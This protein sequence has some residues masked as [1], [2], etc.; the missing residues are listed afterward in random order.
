MGCNITLV[1]AKQSTDADQ[2]LVTIMQDNSKNFTLFLSENLQIMCEH[3]V[4]QSVFTQNVSNFLYQSQ[5][6][7]N[8]PSFRSANSNIKQLLKTALNYKTPFVIQDFWLHAEQLILNQNQHLSDSQKALLTLLHQCSQLFLL[9]QLFSLEFAQLFAH[10]SPSEHHLIINSPTRTVKLYLYQ[11]LFTIGSQA[12]NL[13]SA[14]KMLNCFEFVPLKRSKMEPKY[15]QNAL[16]RLI[17]EC[18]EPGCETIGTVFG[19]EH[20]NGIIF[21]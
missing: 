2:S 9:K 5:R 12:D 6:I 20:E 17:A 14:F 21:E 16:V 7:V 4:Y 18:R 8:F 11:M 13:Q 1:K 10:L 19:F 15:I 3:A